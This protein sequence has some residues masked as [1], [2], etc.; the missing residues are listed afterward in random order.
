MSERRGLASG[1]G[2]RPADVH[3]LMYLI[4]VL[5]S[6]RDRKDAIVLSFVLK[7]FYKMYINKMDQSLIV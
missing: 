3:T 6:T 5:F 2:C 7:Y 4:D 1:A